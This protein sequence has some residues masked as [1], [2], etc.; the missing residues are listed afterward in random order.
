MEPKWIEEMVE[1]AVTALETIA[2]GFQDPP[3]DQDEP[4]PDPDHCSCG[5]PDCPDYVAPAVVLDD[6]VF[7]ED[8]NF[9][10]CPNCGGDGAHVGEHRF[11]CE[12]C[13]HSWTFEPSTVAE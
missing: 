9:P 7:N 5:E 1:R 10:P 11:C 12:V 4:D 2:K 13:H 8:D 6:M 3:A